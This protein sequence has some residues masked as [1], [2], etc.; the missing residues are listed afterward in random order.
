MRRTEKNKEN[1]I[2]Y[3]PSSIKLVLVVALAGVL[4]WAVSFGWVVALFAFYLLFRLIW[5]IIKLIIKLIL[6]TIFLLL[7]ISLTALFIL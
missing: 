3:F 4:V 7:L 1:N 2:S 5:R 6:S